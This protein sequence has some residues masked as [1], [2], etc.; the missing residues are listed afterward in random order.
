MSTP[1]SE[2]SFSPGGGPEKAV[3]GVARPE[4]PPLR[5]LP[6]GSRCFDSPRSE[7]LASS[8]QYVRHSLGASRAWKTGVTIPRAPAPQGPR[9][10]DGGTPQASLWPTTRI[11]GRWRN[12]NEPH[13]TVGRPS[14]PSY[15]WSLG[16][17][18]SRVPFPLAS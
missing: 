8:E 9:V 12:P 5:P 15:L 7:V 10:Q 2:L 18:L 13:I 6:A 3:A 4:N 1:S 16:I 14:G 11:R 17:D